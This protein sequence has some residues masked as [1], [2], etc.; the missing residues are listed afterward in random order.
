MSYVPTVR[1]ETVYTPEPDVR[2]SRTRLVP[3]FEPLP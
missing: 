3:V 1:F 2:V